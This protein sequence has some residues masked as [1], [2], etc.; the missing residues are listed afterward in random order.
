[1]SLWGLWARIWA[2]KQQKLKSSA[3]VRL[4]EYAG[5]HLP[6]GDLAKYIDIQTHM[7]MCHVCEIRAFSTHANELYVQL[8]I[9]I[10]IYMGVRFAVRFQTRMAFFRA[11]NSQ[12]DVPMR[13]PTWL[14]TYM[15]TNLWC[16]PFL[17]HRPIRL[18][19]LYSPCEPEMTRLLWY[20]AF[21]LICFKQCRGR[22]PVVFS[23]RSSP[24]IASLKVVLKK[25]D[26]RV[27]EY[28]SVAE[29]DILC[30]FRGLC[31]YECTLIHII[32]IKRRIEGCIGAG[33]STKCTSKS[34]NFNFSFPV[35]CREVYVGKYQ[36][37]LHLILK[38][39]CV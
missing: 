14:E 3:S 20:S 15:S 33:Y 17:Q 16:T 27:V 30:A 36:F 2:C 21:S 34:F 35:A 18:N 19:S 39:M 1:M 38:H 23:P 24:S 28:L 10:Y 4:W 29:A 22:D 9:Y 25:K 6:K 32:T 37:P 26:P 8:Y 11:L 31:A 13:I 12:P 5:G 7:C